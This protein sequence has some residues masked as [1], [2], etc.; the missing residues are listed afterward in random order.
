MYQKLQ[1][2]IRSLKDEVSKISDERKNKLIQ[3]ADF[4]KDK[5]AEGNPAKLTFICTHNS[6]RSHLC[7]IWAAIL[8]D[9]LDVDNVRSFSGGTE[10]TA[11]NSRAV[12]ALKR[13]GFKIEKTEEDKNPKYKVYFDE[14]TP[15][16]ICYSK[17]FDDPYNPQDDFAAV[18]TCSDADQNCPQ[19]PGA[20]LRISIPYKDPKEADGTSDEVEVYNERCRQIATE[21][22]YLMS[23]V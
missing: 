5:K 12:D 14:D 2:Y 3:I 23:E 21:I 17:K 18:M 11:F 19:V 20:T 4:I 22:L 8:A 10:A 1:I 6:R 15:P 9:Y 16:Q 7:Q 13:V